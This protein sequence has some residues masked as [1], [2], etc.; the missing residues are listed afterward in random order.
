[1]MDYP[2]PFRENRERPADTVPRLKCSACPRSFQTVEALRSH[3]DNNHPLAW[4]YEKGT[5]TRERRPKTVR[6][7]ERVSTDDQTNLNQERRATFYMT[8]RGWLAEEDK[9]KA[10]RRTVTVTREGRV[11]GERG[12]LRRTRYRMSYE[13]AEGPG[14]VMYAEQQSG[15]AMDNRPALMQMLNDLEPGDVVLIVRADRLSRSLTDFCHITQTIHERGAELV[16]I[17]QP[18]DTTTP[19]GRAFWQVLGVFAEL[20]R[21]LIVQRT[22]DGLERAKAE[23]K[24]L[25]RHPRGCGFTYPCPWGVDHVRGGKTTTTNPDGTPKA[26]VPPSRRKPFGAGGTSRR[27]TPPVQVSP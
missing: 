3:V 20:E 5:D 15:K 17:E 8:M 16:C 9:L 23:G 2:D 19:M 7:Y 13:R 26:H 18:V 24:L 10:K 1:M 25:G 14:F 27:K 21:A 4:Q 6:I 12:N 11:H 22:R